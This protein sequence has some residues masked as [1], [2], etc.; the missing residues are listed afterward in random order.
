MPGGRTLE[1]APANSE[2][3]RGWFLTTGR[4]DEDKVGPLE[5]AP[6]I[7]VPGGGPLEQGPADSEVPMG[8]LP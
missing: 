1:Q 6:A 5:L 8:W 2:V 3:P 7:C 4:T